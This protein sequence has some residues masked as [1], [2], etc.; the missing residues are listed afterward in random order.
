MERGRAA[1]ERR[2]VGH[3]DPIGQF[4]FERVHVGSER[5]DPVRVEGV[6]QERSLLRRGVWR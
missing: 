6:E 1:G 2:S 4:P 3:P 5:R